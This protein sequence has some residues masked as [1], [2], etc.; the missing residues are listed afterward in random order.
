MARDGKQGVGE[1]A[2]ALAAPSGRQMR[3]EAPA[4]RP[5]PVTGSAPATETPD[6]RHLGRSPAWKPAITFARLAWQDLTGRHAVVGTPAQHLAAAEAWLRRAH[7]RQEHGADDGVSYGYSIR[8]G[9]RPSYRETSGYI[10]TT[11]FDIA[12]ERGDAEYRQR[13]IRVAE[14][15]LGVQ[16]PDGSIANP[17]YGQEGIVFDTGQVLFGLV[18][19]YEETHRPEFKTA[20]TRAA[21]WLVG[22]ADEQ[23]LWTRC[24]HLNTAH[25]YNTR[26]AWALLR[27]NQV[28]YSAE[29]ERVAR[30]NLDWAVSEQQPSGFFDNCAFVKGAAPFTHTIAYATRG[31]L[32]SGLLLGDERY[33]ESARRCAQAAMRHLRPDGFLPG[34][35]SVAGE[36]AAR[37][38]CVTGNAQFAI[39]WYKLHEL[40]DEHALAD[41]ATRALD[42]V[43]SVQDIRTADAD[44]RGAIRGSF[45]IWGRY[46]PLSYP[47]WPAKFFIDAMRLR[48]RLEGK[49]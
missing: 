44:I 48:Q 46:A 32:E 43:M 4:A 9:W 20:A 30:A 36:E 23:G 49:S 35:I 39:S 7:D 47:N 38:C 31:L 26:S 10:L 6:R 19:A 40:G 17:R 3:V 33:V 21:D 5:T 24:E 29:R 27:M 41:A 42:Y 34:Q 1:A 14:W 13:A 25:V 2:V 15:L 16:N 12:R 11:F 18:R 45:P 28:D 8:G 22:V 37:Y